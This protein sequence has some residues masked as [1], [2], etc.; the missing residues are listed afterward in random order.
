MVTSKKTRHSSSEPRSPE[1]RR[2]QAQAAAYWGA[3]VS[4]PEQKKAQGR[5]GHRAV[6]TRRVDP[7]GTLAR[8]DPGEFARRYALAEKALLA[9]MN[10]AHSRKAAEKRM[11]KMLHYA[12]LVLLSA[13]PVCNAEA[14]LS[15]PTGYKQELCVAH[16]L[17]EKAERF[18]AI[19]DEAQARIAS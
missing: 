12:P 19:L 18:G 10:A 7:D 16:W 9:E 11:A 1:E 6:I 5:A 8:S 15:V 17:V 3:A 2:L 13:C 4:T 14:G